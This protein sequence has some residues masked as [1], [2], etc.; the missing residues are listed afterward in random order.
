MA[1]ELKTRSRTK[2]PERR[3]TDIQAAAKA[4]F[5]RKG[6]QSTTID[7]VAREA[8]ISKG[9]VYLYFKNKEELYI[10]LMIPVTTKLGELL[11]EFERSLEKGKLKN[12]NQFF[13]GIVSLYKQ[14]YE[15]D[16][17]GI[18]IIQA[19]QQGNLFSS[20]SSGTL[21][22]L[23]KLAKT[24]FESAQRFLSKAKRLGLIRENVDET[25]VADLLWALFVGIV[26]LE[27]S[28]FRATHKNH[29]VETLDYG[30]L[31]IGEAIRL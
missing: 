3:L 4:L 22:Q 25:K 13:R 12:F 23:N 6:Y 31:L 16:A 10:S 27:E 30:F 11:E 8:G 24:N 7:Q 2:S 21:S 15:F 19:F 5:F 28:K 29:L 26:Q 1:A 14:I 20:L 18:R 17:E 9:T